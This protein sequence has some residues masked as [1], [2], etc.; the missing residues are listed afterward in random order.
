MILIAIAGGSCS[1][2]TTLAG[3]IE[4][5][6]LERGLTCAIIPLDNY[7]KRSSLILEERMKINH[8]LPEAF[9]WPLFR[10]HLARLANGKATEMPL[11]DYTIHNRTDKTQ[12]INPPDMV[13]IEGLYTLH[14][15]IIR[16]ICDL[17]IFLDCSFKERRRRR[18]ERDIAERG[19]TREFTEY[20]FDNVAEPAFIKQVRPTIRWAN[21]VACDAKGVVTDVDAFLESACSGNLR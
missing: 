19:R 17:T 15:E 11:Y 16:D 12:R 18:L 4:K 21:I 2:K 5:L 13:V 10:E 6:A 8:D 1:G 7:Y 14:D 20:M 9:D 3:L